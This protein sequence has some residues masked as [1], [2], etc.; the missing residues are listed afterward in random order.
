[1]TSNQTC[2]DGFGD[3]AKHGHRKDGKHYD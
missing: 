2:F 1:M 3:A